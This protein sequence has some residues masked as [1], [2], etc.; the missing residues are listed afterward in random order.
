MIKTLEKIHCYQ[1]IVQ[2]A[3][4]SSRKNY[5]HGYSGTSTYRACTGTLRAG[6]VKRWDRFEN[7]LADMGERP[8]G[9]RLVRPNRKRPFSRCNA[10]WRTPETTPEM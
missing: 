9:A 5:S 8:P 10:V 2:T 4:Q 1:V 7:F 3:L 6:R